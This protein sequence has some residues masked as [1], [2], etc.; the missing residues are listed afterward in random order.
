[1][2]IG[3]V[4]APE[5]V[6]DVAKGPFTF[7]VSLVFTLEGFESVV[8]RNEGFVEGCDMSHYGQTQEGIGFTYGTSFGVLLQQRTRTLHDREG[9]S[10]V[11]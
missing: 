11:E 6:E 8:M 3:I 10:K 4:T 5:T 2:V 9:L 1:M 7:E